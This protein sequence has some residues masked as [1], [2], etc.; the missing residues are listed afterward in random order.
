MIRIWVTGSTWNF[1][2]AKDGSYKPGKSE[3]YAFYEVSKKHRFK[4]FGP[5]VPEGKPKSPFSGIKI[6]ED[7]TWLLWVFATGKSWFNHQTNNRQYEK[8]C[9]VFRVRKNIHPRG[10]A[11]R[12]CASAELALVGFCENIWNFS[13]WKIPSLSNWFFLFYLVFCR[14]MTTQLPL[15]MKSRRST[16]TCTATRPSVDRLPSTFPFAVLW[17]VRSTAQSAMSTRLSQLAVP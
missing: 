9:S 16:R 11:P 17:L 3:R 5:A 1:S 7:Y 14:R 8:R 4:I 10:A 2:E 15:P 12:L 6:L 13:S